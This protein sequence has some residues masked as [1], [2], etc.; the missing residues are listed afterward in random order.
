MHPLSTGVLCHCRKLEAETNEKLADVMQKLL[1]AGV[2]KNES[3][4]ETKLKETMSDW[5]CKSSLWTRLMCFLCFARGSGS[6]Y[7][8]VQTNPTEI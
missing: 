7:R 3:D 2:D 4:R 5:S 1:Q 6:S 8:P